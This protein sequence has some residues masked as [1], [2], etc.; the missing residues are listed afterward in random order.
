MSLSET[1]NSAY[2]DITNHRKHYNGVLG[3]E[4]GRIRIGAFISMCSALMPGS[5][6]DKFAK[7]S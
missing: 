6:M 4:F 2:F 5:F 3:K 1:S 7:T